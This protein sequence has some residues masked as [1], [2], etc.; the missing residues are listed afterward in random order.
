MRPD[1]SLCLFSD[2][3]ERA[4]ARRAIRN[5]AAPTTAN[6]GKRKY[7]DRKQC[8]HRRDSSRIERIVQLN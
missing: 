3:P 8:T 7:K 4:S 6:A 5:A 1:E 2:P